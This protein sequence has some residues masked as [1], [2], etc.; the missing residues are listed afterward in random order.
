MTFPTKKQQQQIEKNKAKRAAE[1]AEKA[2][3]KASKDAWKAEFNDRPLT[4]RASALL[5]REI[6]DPA[7]DNAIERFRASSGVYVPRVLTIKM[8]QAGFI[9]PGL[10]EFGLD[11]TS[12]Y[13]NMGGYR[14]YWH[15]DL[16]G[17]AL[18]Y[19]MNF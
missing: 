16:A 6:D 9:T 5:A 3:D 18:V 15:R 8:Y 2:E 12:C 10:A 4:E 19:S 7:L 13:K 14:A 17:K 11:C 1:A